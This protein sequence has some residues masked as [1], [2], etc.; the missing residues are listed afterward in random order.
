MTK[1]LNIAAVQSELSGASAFFPSYTRPAPE[2]PHPDRP[3]EKPTK[4][5]PSDKPTT[6][7]VRDVRPVLPVPPYGVRSES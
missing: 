5:I 4:T 6:T 1:K 7:P 3:A 2:A